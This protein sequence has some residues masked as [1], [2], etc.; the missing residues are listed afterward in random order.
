MPKLRKGRGTGRSSRQPAED[1]N[2]FDPLE[3]SEEDEEPSEPTAPGS[4]DLGEMIAAAL[5]PLTD[6]LASLEKKLEKP[7]EEVDLVEPSQGEEDQGGSKEGGG[8][9]PPDSEDDGDPSGGGAPEERDVGLAGFA[10]G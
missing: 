4:S 2:P 1:D 10:I 5:R 3:G 7:A 8:G 9:D 6:R